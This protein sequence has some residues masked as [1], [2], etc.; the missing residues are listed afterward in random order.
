MGRLHK[1][2]YK[3]D[4]LIRP[5]D[6]EKNAIL[7]LHTAPPSFSSSL[8]RCR[9][10]KARAADFNPST[11]LSHTHTHTLRNGNHTLRAVST[12]HLPSTIRS[13][14]CTTV[15]VCER[16][17]G[18]QFLNFSI[19]QHLPPYRSTRVSVFLSLPPKIKMRSKPT[20]LVHNMHIPVNPP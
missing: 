5:R 11:A 7:S 8:R 13:T 3:F 14:S 1:P 6:R 10:E 16:V 12:W 19:N 20:V 17:Q 9:Q 18:K 15:P 4:R 2:G